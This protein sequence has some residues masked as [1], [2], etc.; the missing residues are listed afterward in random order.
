MSEVVPARMTELK[1][2]AHEL[3]GFERTYIGGNYEAKKNF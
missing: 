1:E 3:R 2:M